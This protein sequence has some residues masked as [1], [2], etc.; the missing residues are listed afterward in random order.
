MKM[1]SVMAGA[2]ALSALCGAAGAAINN[3][4]N[5]FGTV[6]GQ[7]TAVAFPAVTNASG[8]FFVGGMPA[9]QVGSQLREIA[10]DLR[11]QGYLVEFPKSNAKRIIKLSKAS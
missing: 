7:L 3:T 8:N 6:G 1:K 9:S 10:P 5:Y 11:Q 2:V 4:G